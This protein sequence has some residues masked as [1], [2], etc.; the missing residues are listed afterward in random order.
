MRHKVPSSAEVAELLTFQSHG[1]ASGIEGAWLKPLN[2]QDPDEGRLPW[3]A[4]G[5][6]HWEEDRG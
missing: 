4:F 3:G 2:P 6:G 5:A 1:P